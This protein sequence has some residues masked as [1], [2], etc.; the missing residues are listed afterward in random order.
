[1][2]KHNQ[3]VQRRNAGEKERR[4][5]T[6]GPFKTTVRTHAGNYSTSGARQQIHQSSRQT[7]RFSTPGGRWA[8]HG[9]AIEVV[10]RPTSAPRDQA[11]KVILRTNFQPHF[12]RVS[13]GNR[14][15][16]SSLWLA[17]RE[18]L[19][20]E[21]RRCCCGSPAGFFTGDLY[22]CVAVLAVGRALVYGSPDVIF[23]RGSADQ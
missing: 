18:T 20:R 2:S 19:A 3:N 9:A 13:C 14:L 10:G 17:H 15:Q 7:R 11:F 4:A 22:G 1:M 12:W 23:R 5:S 16:L 21:R 8:A 6:Y